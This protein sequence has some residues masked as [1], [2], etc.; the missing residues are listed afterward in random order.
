VNAPLTW[1]KSSAS[2][3]PSGIAAALKAMNGCALRRLFS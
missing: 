3:S 1:P 2:T